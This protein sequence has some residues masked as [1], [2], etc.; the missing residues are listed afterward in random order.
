[1]EK[2]ISF[3]FIL[4]F[5]LSF[6]LIAQENTITI[7][8]EPENCQVKV[9]K[10]VPFENPKGELLIEGNSPL[11]IPKG[12]LKD[13]RGIVIEVSKEGYKTF[14]L[15]S[16]SPFEDS[17]N[18]KLEKTN[19]VGKEENK[20]I[21]PLAEEREI[22]EVKTK[23]TS[24]SWASIVIWDELGFESDGFRGI[25]WGTNICCLKRMVDMGDYGG[26]QIY[27]KRGDYL[28]VGDLELETVGY[29]FWQY[30]FCGVVIQTLGNA[31]WEKLKKAVF[32]EFEKNEAE[33]KHEKNKISYCWSKTSQIVSLTY[34]KISKMG[35]LFYIDVMTI[36]KMEEI[37]AEVIKDFLDSLETISSNIFLYIPAD[38]FKNGFFFKW[39]TPK[40]FVK[41]ALSMKK[42]GVWED[43]EGRVQFGRPLGSVK[44]CLLFRHNKFV[45]VRIFK[46]DS[47]P[48]TLAYDFGLVESNLEAVY[49]KSL[50]EQQIEKLAKRMSYR[51]PYLY[52][53]IKSK[54]ESDF[55][56]FPFIWEIGNTEI[57]L[58]EHS[59]FFVFIICRKDSS[60]YKQKYPII[61]NK[62]R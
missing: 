27:K 62:R 5:L 9:Y 23:K 39:G 17:Y 15:N 40:Y 61:E 48:F 28:R 8:T 47:N 4:P 11:K 3:L 38:K 33:E 13:I 36:T 45:G 35:E 57:S 52:P 14:Q 51:A 31:N 25:K 18:V 29:A 46:F 26:F 55:E 60:P 12:K 44:G 50:K 53:K 32:W 41:R 6:L 21:Q 20:D 19:D 37:T 56:D 22:K 2:R 24:S 16:F 54:L 43:K 30:E 59:N 10:W 7:E 34:D 1:M 42:I 58:M 49:G